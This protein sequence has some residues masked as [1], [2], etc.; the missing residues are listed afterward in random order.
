MPPSEDSALAQR[1]GH[2]GVP[3]GLDLTASGRFGVYNFVIANS[4]QRVTLSEL[5]VRQRGREDFLEEGT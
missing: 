1:H 3:S 2:L 5:G 4:V